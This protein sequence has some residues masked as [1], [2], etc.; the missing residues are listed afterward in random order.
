MQCV[1]KTLAE[2][3][4]WEHTTATVI[5]IRR[6]DKILISPGSYATLTEKDIIYYIGDELSPDRVKNFLLQEI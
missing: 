1:G 2:L 6:D 3:R 5:A 4:F